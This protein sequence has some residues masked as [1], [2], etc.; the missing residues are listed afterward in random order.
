ML[1]DKS[2]FKNYVDGFNVVFNNVKSKACVKEYLIVNDKQSINDVNIKTPKFV[3]RAATA[4][5][6]DL[7]G[8]SIT[9][10]IDKTDQDIFDDNDKAVLANKVSEQDGLIRE[11]KTAHSFLLVYNNSVHVIRNQAIRNPDTGNFLG[12]FSL[13][14][15]LTNPHLMKMIYEINDISY[16]DGLDLSQFSEYSHNKPSDGV[17]RPGKLTKSQHM[18]LF[19]SIKNYSA[20]EIA[21]KMGDLGKKLSYGRVNE[22][23]TNLRY[24]FDAKTKEELTQKAITLNYHK[25][26]P[27]E[28]L[29]PGIYKFEDDNHHVKLF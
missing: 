16:C 10:L 1:D 22:V 24:M 26:I 28:F 15:P 14:S 2:Y 19:F 7:Y 6:A 17:I 27:S 20:R 18:I 21:D 11:N 29:K 5:L 4:E 12:I 25:Y 23:L 13:V 9:Q 3:Y 8:K